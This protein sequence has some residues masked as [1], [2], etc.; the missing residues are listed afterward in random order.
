MKNHKLRKKSTKIYLIFLIWIALMFLLNIS[1][2]IADDPPSSLTIFPDNG[3]VLMGDISIAKVSFN[4][5]IVYTTPNP[6]YVTDSI[7]LDGITS[8]GEIREL[9]SGS[10]TMKFPD[11]QIYVKLPEENKILKFTDESRTSAINDTCYIWS[12]NEKFALKSP[13]TIIVADEINASFSGINFPQQIDVLNEY[14]VTARRGSPYD[15][16][17]S[18]LNYCVVNYTVDWGD[19][20][21]TVVN[22]INSLSLNHVYTNSGIYSVCIRPVDLEGNYYNFSSQLSIYDPE[23]LQLAYVVANT[24]RVPIAATSVG[25]SGLALIGF[26][27]T[28]AGKYKLLSLLSLAIPMFTHIQKDDVLDQFVRGEVY[29]LI[30]SNPGVHYNEIMRKLEMKNGTLSYHLHMLEK[31]EMIKSRR[32]GLKYRVFYPTEM[33][34]PKEERYRLSNLQLEIL[35]IIK[36]D[37]GIQQKEIAKKLGKKPQT[38][39]YNIKILQ[40][41]GLIKIRKK[42]RETGCYILKESPD[43]QNNTP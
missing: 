18:N 10:I 8:I 35:Q 15:M 28:E 2:V 20:T 4:D 7:V 17:V 42:G 19:G 30:K 39:N 27:A 33:K 1:I 26:A 23:G 40:Q 29:G 12:P 36:E 37:E 34:F 11:N 41:A 38:I 14:K 5:T 3:S 43:N 31:M 9:P 16:Q 22:D 21:V 24:Y 13:S 32:E 25:V 6:S